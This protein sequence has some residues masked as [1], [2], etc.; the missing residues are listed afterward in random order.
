MKPY[1]KL[2]SL[3]VLSMA[4]NSSNIVIE[5]NLITAQKSFS[6]EVTDAYLNYTLILNVGNSANDEL[7]ELFFLD[8][9]T[10]EDSLMAEKNSKELLKAV[11][12]LDKLT[13]ETEIFIF[14]DTVYIKTID[15]EIIL[16]PEKLKK[17]RILYKNE[18]KYVSSF[19]ITEELNQRW[20][21]RYQI[22]VDKNDKK[23]INGIEGYKLK[24]IEIRQTSIGQ[25][26]D[27]NEIYMNDSIK[28]P[29]N[30]YEILDLKRRIDISGL[31][32]EVKSYDKETPSLYNLYRLK[33]YNLE[34]QDK[35]LIKT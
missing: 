30:Y 8:A 11:K 7:M 19:E 18:K 17:N 20:K 23:V 6:Q 32:L 2:I 33:S 35:K 12:K 25:L 22:E 34:K 24:L 1:C 15:S 3:F 31:I 14:P 21:T 13:S 28:I 26:I 16:I 9:E 27:I 4:C 29:F 10:K 5:D